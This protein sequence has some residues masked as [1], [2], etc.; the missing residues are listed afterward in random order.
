MSLYDELKQQ[1]KNEK[2][3]DRL[4]QQKWTGE[5]PEEIVMKWTDNIYNNMVAGIKEVIQHK[6]I[7]KESHLFSDKYY[8]QYY[9]LNMNKH[10]CICEEK[11]P[12][13]WNS[14][15]DGYVKLSSGYDSTYLY[16]GNVENVKRILYKVQ[17]RLND[18]KLPCI[19]TIGDKESRAS[20]NLWHFTICIKVPCLSDGTL[21]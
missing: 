9:Y 20:D 14:D 19:L 1:Q 12:R 4:A 16:C 13:Y 15:F 2:E 11:A 3:A 6:R 10:L 21:I 17:K 8:Y 18:E 7:T 5:I